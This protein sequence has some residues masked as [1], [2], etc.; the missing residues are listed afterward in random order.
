MESRE[1]K[2]YETKNSKVDN[3]DGSHKFSLTSDR[4]ELGS[5]NSMWK[6]ISPGGGSHHRAAPEVW[7]TGS[8]R[9]ADYRWADSGEVDLQLR[10]IEIY[11]DYHPEGWGCSPN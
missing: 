3:P 11:A 10:L 5:I 9:T 4:T 1:G 8:P 7:R 6:P 2:R